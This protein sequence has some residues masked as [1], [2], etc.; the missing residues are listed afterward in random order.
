MFTL[1]D[2]MVCKSTQYVIE[3]NCYK[4]ANGTIHQLCNAKK[5]K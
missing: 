4:V 3:S 2:V 1:Y 5:E